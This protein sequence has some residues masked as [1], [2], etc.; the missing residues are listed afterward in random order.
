MEVMKTRDARSEGGS[1]DQGWLRR[2]GNF[3]VGSKR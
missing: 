1:V 3:G 2:R